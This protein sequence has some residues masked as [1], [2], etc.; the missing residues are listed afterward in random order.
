MYL[1][2]H[3]YIIYLSIYLI[4]NNKKKIKRKNKSNISNIKKLKEIILLFFF[5]TA[6]PAG[7]NT[8][9]DASQTANGENID[10]LNLFRYLNSHNTVCSLKR[11][12]HCVSAMLCIFVCFVFLVQKKK[13]TAIGNLCDSNTR[14]GLGLKLHHF[15]LLVHYWSLNKTCS[16]FSV[17]YNAL[18]S[19]KTLK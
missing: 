13:K 1:F 3:K 7:Q 11:N 2:W 10:N 15:P 4:I 14:L 16:S 9:F 18:L 8:W 19:I 5:R 12:R 17:N 6:W